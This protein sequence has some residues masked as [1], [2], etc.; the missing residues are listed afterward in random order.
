MQELL[1]AIRKAL[2]DDSASQGIDQV[3]SV[4]M[5]SQ[6]TGNMSC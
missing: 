2:Q 4:W 1:F 6:T 5:D 3:V